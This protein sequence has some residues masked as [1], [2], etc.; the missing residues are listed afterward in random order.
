MSTTS[1]FVELTELESAISRVNGLLGHFDET[2]RG[3]D[4]TV[5]DLHCSWAGESAVAHSEVHMGWMERATGLHIS[6]TE[7]RD[8]LVLAQSSYHAAGD[9]NRQMFEGN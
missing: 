1:I 8:K 2:F 3:I 9:A 7:I 5:V 4:A 6:L